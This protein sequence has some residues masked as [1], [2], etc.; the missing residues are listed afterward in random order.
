MAAGFLALLLASLA[1]PQVRNW[2]AARFATIPAS[3]GNVIAVLPLET[4]GSNRQAAAMIGGLEESLS[5]R[6]AKLARGRGLEVVPTRVMREEGVRSV[7]QAR[8]EFGVHFV[9]DWS[10]HQ[11]GDSYRVTYALVDA[12]TGRSL[13]GDSITVPAGD[14]LGVENAVV[15]GVARMLE[16]QAG[17]QAE[18]RQEQRATQVA[19]AYDFFLQ[20]RGYAQNYDRPENLDSAIQVFERAIALDEKFALAYAGL[21]EAYWKKFESAKQPEWVDKARKACERALQ[22]DARGAAGHVCLGTLLNGTG[23]YERAAEEMQKALDD[24]PIN[25]DAYRGLGRAYEALNQPGQAERTFKRAIEVRPHYWAGYSWLG[26]FYFAQGRFED[27]AAM[28]KQMVALAPDSFWGYSNLGGVLLA[29]GHYAEAIEQFKRSAAI[30]STAPAF[31]NLATAYFALHQFEEAADTY[32]K[33]IALDER[34][35]LL[36]GNLGEAQYWSAQRRSQSGA[37]LAKAISLAE[38]R[39]RV[40]PRDATLLGYLAMYHALRKETAQADRRLKQALALAPRDADLYF[41]AALLHQL[42]GRRD[43]AVA[44]VKRCLEAGYPSAVVR[45]YPAFDSLRDDPSLK[46]LFAKP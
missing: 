10:L 4:E 1:I 37:S 13:D 3:G 26:G 15:G 12:Q 32:A 43:V 35:Y 41:K 17:A 31:S 20:G 46:P 33:A 19:G 40:N 7:T 45:D 8:K 25:D 38:E 21:G 27:A 16:L 29:Q 11:T 2:V 23:E 14:S 39:L 22:L 9:V 34:N 28:F 18:S 30:R 6:L 44:W 24:D 5:V 42:A 36:W